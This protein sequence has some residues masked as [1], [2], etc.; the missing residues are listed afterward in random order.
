[1]VSAHV[2]SVATAIR[3]DGGRALCQRRDCDMA[4]DEKVTAA[5]DEP[6]PGHA[7]IA[8]PRAETSAGVK[9]AF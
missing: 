8:W 9:R 4:G 2:M 6:R 5:L 3:R 7:A 1:V